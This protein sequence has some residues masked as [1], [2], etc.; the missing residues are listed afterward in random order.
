MSGFKAD[1]S[2]TMHSNVHI[3]HPQRKLNGLFALHTVIYL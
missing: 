1:V 2:E 3:F